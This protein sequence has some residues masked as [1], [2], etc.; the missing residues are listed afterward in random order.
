M[1]KATL[2]ATLIALGETIMTLPASPHLM[3]HP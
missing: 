2:V 3:V 1:K